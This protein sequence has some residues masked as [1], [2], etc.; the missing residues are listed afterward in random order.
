MTNDNKIIGLLKETYELEDMNKAEIP[1]IRNL[2]QKINKIQGIMS[3]RSKKANQIME[4]I[5]KMIKEA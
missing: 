5:K 1:I 2:H 4:N 3:L